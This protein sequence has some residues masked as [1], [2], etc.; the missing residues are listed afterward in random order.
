MKPLI[1]ASLFLLPLAAHADDAKRC[2]HS[3]NLDLRLDLAGVKTVTFDMSASDLDLRATGEGAGVVKGRA[4]ASDAKLLAPITL[5]QDKQG[6]RLTLRA[7]RNGENDT[8][9]RFNLD[10]FGKTHRRYAELSVRAT[11]PDDLTVELKTGSGDVTV[12]GVHSLDAT[13]GSGDLNVSN[14]PGP[15][16][17]S[18][19]SGDIRGNDLGAL[20]LRSIGS[21]DITIRQVRGAARIG[22]FGSGDIDIRNTQGP[23]DIGTGGSGDITLTDIGGNVTVGSIGSGDI[24]VDGA[25]GNLTVRSKGS[26]D[27]EHRGITGRVDLPGK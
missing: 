19:G 4:C 10:L 24:D 15:F 13:L 22:S 8:G 18:T 27:I 25:R 20:G 16:S 14:I 1:F 6:D 12:E 2:E 17:G 5:T 26:G 23:V 11:V 3:R 21:G 7:R 9:L